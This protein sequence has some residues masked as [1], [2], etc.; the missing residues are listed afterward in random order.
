MNSLDLLHSAPLKEEELQ[1]IA[2]RIQQLG[3]RAPM[4]F[5]LE[6]LKPLS[7]VLH[8]GSVA[9]YP[10]LS[11]VVGASLSRKLISLLCCRDDIEKLIVSLEQIDTDSRDHDGI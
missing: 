10:L 3:L 1:A 11:M 9:A 6:M 4:V 2:K 8:M 7:G 5:I